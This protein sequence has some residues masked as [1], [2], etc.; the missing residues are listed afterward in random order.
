VQEQSLLKH[1][2]Q[3]WR[4]GKAPDLVVSYHNWTIVGGL[5]LIIGILAGIAQVLDYWQ[6]QRE[7][8]REPVREEALVSSVSAPAVPSNLPPRAEFIGREKEKAR[9]WEALSSH[10]PL[11]CIDGI[12]GIGK[13]ALA[14]EVAAECLRASKGEGPANGMPTFNGFI[15]TTAKDRELT[16]N[17]LSMRET[18][19]KQSGG[20]RRHW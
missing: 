15:W 11:T 19:A 6:K 3:A 2:D 18:T 16:E 14:L 9:V 20:S 13:T 7:K 5:A 10:W 1:Q 17:L 12:G 8:K 4:V